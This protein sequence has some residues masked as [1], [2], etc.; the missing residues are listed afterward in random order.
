MKNIACELKALPEA[1]LKVGEG[2]IYESPCV[3]KTVL[4]SCVSVSFFSHNYSVGGIFHALLPGTGMALSGVSLA[5]RYRFVGPAI[6]YICN[7]MLKRG[8][9]RDQIETK[10]FGG[11]S[12]MQSGF[13]V[14]RRNVEEA[15]SILEKLHLRVV[16]SNVGGE[17]GRK[18][19][20][21]SDTGEVFL[22]RLSNRSACNF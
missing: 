11:A 15:Y 13:N 7:E 8:I 12:V 6:E 16:A 21:R 4:G 14:G 17:F 5:E 3:V 20:F 10:V 1:Y 2:G 22:K 9:R 18:L 19:L